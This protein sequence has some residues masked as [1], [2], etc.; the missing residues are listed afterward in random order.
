M[1][2]GINVQNWNFGDALSMQNPYWVANRM[3]RSNN[4]SRYMISASLKYK[5]FDWMDVVG[6]LRWDDAGTKQEDKRYA[7][8]TNLFAHSKYGFYGYDK[9]NDRSLYGDLMFNI[10]KTLNDFSVSANLGGSFTRNKYNVTGFQGGLKAPSNLFT[11]N[12]I[13]YGAATA[14]NRPIFTDHAHKI[15]SLFANV[16]LG[17]RS[18]LFY[19]C[20]R[21]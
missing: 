3:V 18:M 13:D 8:T 10:N 20:N 7:S 1:T 5:I 2:R 19:D 14:D 16:E 15:N 17:W 11:P 4:R 21:S 12:A 9:V 6:R